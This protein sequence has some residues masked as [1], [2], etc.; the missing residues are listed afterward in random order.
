MISIV[1]PSLNQAQYIPQTIQSVL[2]QNPPPDEYWII[3][4]RS[5]DETLTIL[6]RYGQPLRWISESDLG[7]ADAI[8]KGTRLSHGEILGWINSDD[9]YQPGA[10]QTILHEF[11]IDPQ[12]MLL[13]GYANHID[14]DGCFLEKYPSSEFSL[15][16]LAYHCFICQPSCFYRRTLWEAAGGLNVNLHYAMDLDLWIRFGKL[17][18]QHPEWNFKQIPQLLA[19][20]RMY[21][22]NKTLYKRE[23][24]YRE[25]IQVV[26][27]HFSVVPYNLIYGMI[28]SQ[29][30]RH[31]GFFSRRPFSP[32]LFL[33]SL[34]YW[35][36]QNRKKPSYIFRHVWLVLISP[37]QSFRR[38]AT[39]VQSRFPTP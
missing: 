1:T 35:F 36:W 22:G 26:K 23:E 19:H 28:E 7:Q 21:S 39:R 29:N 15:E 24:S 8:N 5:S 4:G 32:A 12:L 2:D 20:S 13:Y 10:F 16:A 27:S 31:D 11:S 34:L 30:S 3:D 9:L 33:R 38:I 6:G 37:V 18:Q 17:R 14:Q 25:T